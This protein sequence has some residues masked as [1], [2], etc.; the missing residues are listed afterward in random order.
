M[1]APG[2]IQHLLQFAQ[3]TIEPG[4]IVAKHKHADLYEIF[5]VESGNGVIRINDTEHPIKRDMSITVEPDEYHE[6]ENT[7]DKKLTL[8]YFAILV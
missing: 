5:F 7:G 1:I 2:E 6:V 4:E 3:A 8:T